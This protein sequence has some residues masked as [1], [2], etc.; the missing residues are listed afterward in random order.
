MACHDPESRQICDV[1]PYQ[2]SLATSSTVLRAHPALTYA[3]ALPLEVTRELGGNFSVA[4]ELGERDD[5]EWLR[6]HRC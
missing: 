5:V 3:E 1:C 6:N 4:R 2:R